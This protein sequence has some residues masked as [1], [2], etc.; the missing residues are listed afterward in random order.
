PRDAFEPPTKRPKPNPTSSHASAGSSQRRSPRTDTQKI[1]VILGT[2]K[3]QNWTFASFLF[4]IFRIKDTNGNEI[5]R[6]PTHSQM[7]S[8]FLAGRASKTVG[9]IV[10]EWMAHPDG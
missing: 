2:I 5:N 9:N 1:E 3:D 7:V 8:I 6:S 4:N 10:S